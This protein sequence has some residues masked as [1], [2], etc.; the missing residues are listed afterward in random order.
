MV[1]E[2]LLERVVR[3]TEVQQ[4]GDVVHGSTQEEVSGEE[5]EEVEVGLERSLPSL[6]PSILPP[7]HVDV[8][9]T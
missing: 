1:V 4:E 7:F 6:S 9:H 2:F 8:L 3:A 5:R